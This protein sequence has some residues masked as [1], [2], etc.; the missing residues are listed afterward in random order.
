MRRT[1]Q[2]QTQAK[3]NEL[4]NRMDKEVAESFTYKQ[5]KAL[6]QC[7]S[8]REWRKHPIDFRPTIA[9]PLFPWSFY[10]VLLAGANK[11]ELTNAER[12]AGFLMFFVVIFI[13]ALLL[14]GCAL[15]LIYLLKSWLGID[16]FPNESLGIWE[17]FKAAFQT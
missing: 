11:R 13:F 6:S 8:V 12:L 7:L 9:L 5:R 4:L 1:T 17:Q 15:L 14:I 16:L 2:R 10:L 3:L